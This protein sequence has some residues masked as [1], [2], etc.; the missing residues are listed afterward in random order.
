M[1]AT[2]EETTQISEFTKTEASL[3]TLET[4]YA[5]VPD[6]TTKDGYQACADA[7]RELRPLRTGLD[8]MRLALNADDQA[9]I[10]FR[11]GEAKRITAR[12][13]AL[14]DPIKAAKQDIDDQAEREAEVIRQNEMERIEGITSMID[15]IRGLAQVLPQDDAAK[16]QSNLDSI[17][18][19][20]GTTFAEYSEQANDALNATILTLETALKVREEF[21]AQQAENARIASDQ[22]ERQAELDK[23]AE[24]QRQAESQARDKL[25]AEKASV[26]KAEQAVADEKHAAEQAKLDEE[27]QKLDAQRLEQETIEAERE[28]LKREAD[29]RAEDDRL[30]KE[31]EV[32]AAADEAMKPEKQKLTDWLKKLRFIDGVS[33]E[34]QDLINIQSG[35]LRLLDRESKAAVKEVE[36]L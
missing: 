2:A 13:V 6:A 1:S 25:D 8:K 15:Y 9:K 5:K 16:I 3:S 14:E 30:A 31:A 20:D 24:T 35:V 34:N 21:E 11:N 4:K 22:A 23:Q 36:A 19:I 28:K 7:I 27:R 32:K 33:L 17:A 26:R 29:Q 10:K 12:L 18:K